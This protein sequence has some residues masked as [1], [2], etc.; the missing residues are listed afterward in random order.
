MRT[1]PFVRRK[2][3]AT[4]P[5][6][7]KAIQPEGT[8]HMANLNVPG[9][10]ADG[11]AE[12]KDVEQTVTDVEKTIADVKAKAPLATIIED[13]EKVTTDLGADVSTGAKIAS[14]L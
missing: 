3:V 6:P 8:N 9:L 10:V 14:D 5:Q 11:S 4:I 13:V 7:G 12:I 1:I 2:I